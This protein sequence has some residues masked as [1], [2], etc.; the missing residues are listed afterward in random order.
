MPAQGGGCWPFRTL[1]RSS[2]SRAS[3]GALSGCGSISAGVDELSRRIADQKPRPS[4]NAGAGLQS[5]RVNGLKHEKPRCASAAASSGFWPQD[6]D[7]LDRLRND[8]PRQKMV[9]NPL[10]AG[11]NRPREYESAS[12]HFPP[13]DFARMQSPLEAVEAESNATPPNRAPINSGDCEPQ[14]EKGQCVS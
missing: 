6:P 3:D 10:R 2:K 5:V 8:S 7:C 4:R 9:G 12:T 13:V 11:D 1:C 14:T